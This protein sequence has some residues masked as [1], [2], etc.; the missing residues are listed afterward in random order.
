[1]LSLAS[2]FPSLLARMEVLVKARVPPESWHYFFQQNE[3]D[4]NGGKSWDELVVRHA[5]AVRRGRSLNQE[6]VTETREQLDAAENA[7]MND[8][9]LS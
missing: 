7:P 1:M 9:R 3:T 6:R 5:N 8:W 2:A 4:E